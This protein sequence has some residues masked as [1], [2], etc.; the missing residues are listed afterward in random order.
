MRTPIHTLSPFHPFTLPPSC[1]LSSHTL[2]HGFMHIP[3]IH[4]MVAGLAPAPA[5]QP[6]QTNCRNMFMCSFVFLEVTRPS[7]IH[8]WYNPRS[9]RRMTP[10]FKVL[11]LV[12]RRHG[13]SISLTISFLSLHHLRGR[14]GRPTNQLIASSCSRISGGSKALEVTEYEDEAV[15]SR[16][17]LQLLL[18]S[19]A[20][21]GS[22]CH[23][24]Y[25]GRH[26]LPC[27]PPD[28]SS[29]S[30]SSLNTDPNISSQS[31][32]PPSLSAIH[33]CCQSL[34][35]TRYQTS[36]RPSLDFNLDTNHIRHNIP[37]RASRATSVNLQ[38]TN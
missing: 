17:I 13:G 11:V 35:G 30:Q 10:P 1:P 7:R 31:T 15:H 6:L 33:L 27:L 14:H 19:R 16:Y 24:V 22:S 38:P 8:C 18:S 12:H 20:P 21:K 28:L 37:R 25:K 26:I 3:Y 29:P 34:K 36:P 5:Q 2:I 4:H 9:S 32:T 23:H